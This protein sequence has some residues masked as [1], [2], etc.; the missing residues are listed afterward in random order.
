MSSAVIASA[1]KHVLYALECVVHFL[2]R[3]SKSSEF[4]QYSIDVS[5]Y[6]IK[7]FVFQNK[8]PIYKMSTSIDVCCRKISCSGPTF[9]SKS[10]E[11]VDHYQRQEKVINSVISIRDVEGLIDGVAATHGGMSTLNRQ[12][13]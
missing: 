6:V 2:I 1:C 12:R 3:D 13:Q 9:S 8:G 10:L 4:V 11:G 5:M 7:G